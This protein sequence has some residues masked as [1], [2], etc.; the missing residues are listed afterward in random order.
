MEE[1]SRSGPSAYCTRDCG[2]DP[3]TKTFMCMNMYVC[4][5]SGCFLCIII[6]KQKSVDYSLPRIQHKPYQCLLLTR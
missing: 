2:S 5:G 3:R 6:Y 4:I 1:I